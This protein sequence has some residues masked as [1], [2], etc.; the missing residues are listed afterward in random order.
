MT[1]GAKSGDFNH[2][3]TTITAAMIAESGEDG[4]DRVVNVWDIETG[5]LLRTLNRNTIVQDEVF[6]VLHNPVD[7]RIV[8]GYGG[9]NNCVVWND[10]RGDALLNLTGHIKP[11]FFV[12]FSPT[13][14]KIVSRP[15]DCTFMM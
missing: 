13:G 12:A 4:D 6:S 7:G 9:D 1:N 2:K 14:L 11:G 5:V 3:G 8:A 10:E 15:L